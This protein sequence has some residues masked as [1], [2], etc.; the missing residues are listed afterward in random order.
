MSFPIVINTA[1]LSLPWFQIP[2]HTNFMDGSTAPTVTLPAGTFS[3]QQYGGYYADF[4]FQVT[5]SGT[6]E[7]DAAFEGFF[8]RA[9]HFESGGGRVRD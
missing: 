4:K 9:R 8:G 6:I 2:G 3:F 7:Y 1:A 5:S